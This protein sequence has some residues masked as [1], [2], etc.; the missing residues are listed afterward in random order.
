MECHEPKNHPH[1]NQLGTIRRGIEKLNPKRLGNPILHFQQGIM[2]KLITFQP[3]HGQNVNDPR[4][5]ERP[6]WQPQLLQ[7][8]HCHHVSNTFYW[9][10]NDLRNIKCYNNLRLVMQQN[11]ILFDYIW[12]YF[13]KSVE[14]SIR[15]CLQWMIKLVSKLHFW[16]INFRF[17][18][19]SSFA[20]TKIWKEFPTKQL[21]I[22]KNSWEY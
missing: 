20:K 14:K 3:L 12:C 21:C 8:Q 2:T 18:N 1:L 11:I 10:C 7:L 5:Q 15:G 13:D 17:D 22:I 19:K 9:A 4:L 16:R 6:S